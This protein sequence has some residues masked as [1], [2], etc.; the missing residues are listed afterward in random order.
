MGLWFRIKVCYTHLRNDFLFLG[1][2]YI[3]ILNKGH[4]SFED[5]ISNIRP[6]THSFVKC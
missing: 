6:T 2:T 3:R 1:F 4:K 5:L